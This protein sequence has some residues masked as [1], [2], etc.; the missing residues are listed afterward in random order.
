MITLCGFD[1][2]LVKLRKLISRPAAYHNPGLGGFLDVAPPE[3][4]HAGEQLIGCSS[5]DRQLE[6]ESWLSGREAFVI[7]LR[8]PP[9]QLAQ[10]ASGPSGLVID[11]IRHRLAEPSYF[12]VGDRRLDGFGAPAAGDC[13][14]AD[15]GAKRTGS[16]EG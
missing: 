5:G 11:L 7:S 4:V 2:E 3:L 9:A 1:I 13:G 6:D 10:L 8:L 14:R 16:A 12:F 15:P